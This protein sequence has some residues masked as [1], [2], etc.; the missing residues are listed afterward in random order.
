M[1]C[2]VYAKF[3]AIRTLKPLIS[4]MEEKQEIL[5]IRQ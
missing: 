1:I 2:Y 4:R 3:K 5:S